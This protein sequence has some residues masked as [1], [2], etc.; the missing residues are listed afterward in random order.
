M[1]SSPQPLTSL[2]H[3]PHEAAGGHGRPEDRSLF[4]L[5]QM[6]SW[7]KLCQWALQ[8]AFVYLRQFAS[9]G[10][11]GIILVLKVVLLIVKKS[12]IL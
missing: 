1:I 7:M 3:M 5:H 9:P 2:P 8:Q 10:F 6:G 11:N 4:S 12:K